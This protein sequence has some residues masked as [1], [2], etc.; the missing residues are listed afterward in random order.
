MAPQLPPV[1][2]HETILEWWTNRPAACLFM[3]AALALGTAFVALGE[4]LMDGKV[5]LRRRV[6]ARR[7]SIGALHTAVWS[8]VGAIY[9][10][11]GPDVG[12]LP[13]SGPVCI[14]LGGSIGMVIV[15]RYAWHDM[16]GRMP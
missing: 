11:L 7:V 3:L 1:V 10:A 2:H 15:A 6:R 4:S 13:T 8:L 5:G 12:V 16:H 9:L 14:A